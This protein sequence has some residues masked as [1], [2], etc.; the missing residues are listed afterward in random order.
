[1][2]GLVS[3]ESAEHLNGN[4]SY[5]WD[6]SSFSS[7]GLWEH[8]H[9]WAGAGQ[10]LS[11]PHSAHKWSRDLP[12]GC[13]GPSGEEGVDCGMV[14]TMTLIAEA[15]GNF[16]FCCC[17][18]FK[19]IFH[20]STFIFLCFLF[21]FVV[22]YFVFCSFHFCFSVCFAGFSVIF[23]FFFCFFSIFQISVLCNIYQW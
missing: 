14:G 21:V 1:M 7:S 10:S 5:N 19:Y 12:R 22:S 3:P 18:I 23:V 6:Q 9:T 8:I 2:I 13:G 11:C 17:L 20:F 16:L 4:I 15:T